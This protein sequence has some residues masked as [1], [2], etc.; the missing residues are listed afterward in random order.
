MFT[1]STS[2]LEGGLAVVED[3]LKEQVAGLELSNIFLLCGT[4]ALKTHIKNLVLIVHPDKD[5]E[6]AKGTF[7]TNPADGDMKALETSMSFLQAII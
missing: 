7:T 4:S 2:S 5:M 3:I 6:I 1:N